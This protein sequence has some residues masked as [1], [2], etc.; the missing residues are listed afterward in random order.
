MD[1]LLLLRPAIAPSSWQTCCFLLRLV[2]VLHCP[3]LHGAAGEGTLQENLSIMLAPEISVRGIRSP[4]GPS[5]KRS[6]TQLFS[7][8][9]V[10]ITILC[11]YVCVCDALHLATQM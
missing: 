3:L 9:F 6:A 5:I 4:E 1:I 2:H 7:L 11:W 10:P 8:R